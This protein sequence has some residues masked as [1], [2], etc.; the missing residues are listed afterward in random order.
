MIGGDVR[1]STG[2]V[3]PVNGW[4]SS[5][6][7]AKENSDVINVKYFG[8]LPHEFFTEVNLSGAFTEVSVLE[9][10]VSAIRRVIDDF[11]KI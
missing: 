6:Y 11:R 7:G 9:E 10:K 8:K 4:C 2:E 1:I 3:S 5:E